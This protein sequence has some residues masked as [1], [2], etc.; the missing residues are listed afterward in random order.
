MNISEV[1]QT[2]WAKIL[3]AK[4]WVGMT[5]I[6]LLEALHEEWFKATS[7]LESEKDAEIEKWKDSHKIL[8]A[9]IESL[10]TKIKE[11]NQIIENCR[12]LYRMDFPKAIYCLKHE[13]YVDNCV[14][15]NRARFLY[16]GG[17]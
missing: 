9:E 16:E 14:Q 17:V 1:G 4:S 11:S 15:C 13:Y 5:E 2:I 6:K 8:E 7:T 10:K 12:I 3:E